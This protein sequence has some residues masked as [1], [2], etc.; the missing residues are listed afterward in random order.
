MATNETT[1]ITAIVVTALGSQRPSYA[2]V[3]SWVTIT[4]AEISQ[5]RRSRIAVL[6][7]GAG[8]AS[9]VTSRRAPACPS[10]CSSSARARENDVSAAS[11]AE[12]RP[13]SSTSAAARTMIIGGSATS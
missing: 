4:I 13:A 6:R 8:S 9:I 1:S 5:R 11:A 12:K 7:Y 2:R 3:T 10:A